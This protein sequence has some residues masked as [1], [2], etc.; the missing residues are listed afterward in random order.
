MGGAGEFPAHG[1]AGENLW[2]WPSVAEA[3]LTWRP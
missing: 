2:K 1:S 3:W